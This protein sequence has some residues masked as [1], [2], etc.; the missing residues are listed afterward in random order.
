MLGLIVVAVVLGLALFW[1]QADEMER[2]EGPRALTRQRTL[3]SSVLL[4]LGY[5]LRWL[6]FWR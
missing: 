4:V 5:A 3:T 6:V 1:R 2:G